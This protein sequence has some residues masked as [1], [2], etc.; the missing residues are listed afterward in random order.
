M[1]ESKTGLHPLSILHGISMFDDDDERL[2]GMIY[3][4]FLSSFLFFFSFFFS[5][6][7]LSFYLSWITLVA[8]VYD[9]ANKSMYAHT[10]SQIKQMQKSKLPFLL[11]LSRHFKKKMKPS[12]FFMSNFPPLYLG[13]HCTVVQNGHESRRKYWATLSSVCSLLL[14]RSLNS[15][16]PLLMGQ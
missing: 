3:R 7:S 4:P 11:T 12:F 14:H 8:N 10:E 6:F 1:P 16:T 13:H 15:L 2:G 9:P 5:S